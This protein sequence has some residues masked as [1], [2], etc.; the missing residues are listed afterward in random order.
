MDKELQKRIL[1]SIILIPIAT[2]T[3]LKGS[4]FFIFF[5]IL[6]FIITGYEWFNL[7]EK[8]KLL[9]FIGIIF[10]SFSFYS[11]F[12]LRNTLGPD[13]FLFVICICIFTDIGG[14]VFGKILKGPKLT[15]ISPNKTYAGVAGGFILSLIIGLIFLKIFYDEFSNS[16]TLNYLIFISIISLISQIGD[17]IISFFKRKAKMKDTGKLLPGHGGFLDRVDGLIFVIPIVYLYTII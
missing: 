2:F 13:F 16:Y 4:F 5:L 17:L 14:Y 9:K 10:L 1:S 12:S 15:R 11:A 8:K 3:I 6:L 7:T